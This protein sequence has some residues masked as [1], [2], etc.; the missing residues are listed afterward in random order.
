MAQLTQI[1][2][3]GVTYDIADLISGFVTTSVNN[4]ANYYL[5]SDTYTR[6]EVQ[7]LIGA[8]QQFHYEIY[9]SRSEVTSPASNV[10]YLIG[11][12]G[13]GA[14][15][16]EEYVYDA[17]KQDPWVKI[18]DTTI[19][20]SGYVTTQA[21][22]AAL[23]NYTTTA[24]LTT[25]LSGK[26]DVISDLDT[27][28]AGA[29]L[30]STAYQKPSTGIPATDLAI[31]TSSLA[32]VPADTSGVAANF[33]ETLGVTS[34]QLSDLFHGKY[35]YI[36][37]GADLYAVTYAKYSSDLSY[38]IFAGKA[39][40]YCIWEK[41][42]GFMMS[43]GIDSYESQGYYIATASIINTVSYNRSWVFKEGDIWE[44]PASGSTPK[45]M[46]IYHNGAWVSMDSMFPDVSG[47]ADK[48]NNP[49]SGNFAGLDANGNLTDSGKK[50]SDFATAAQGAKADTAI[51]DLSPIT[52]LIPAQASDQNQLADKAYVNSSIGTA[53]ATFRGAYN[54][55]TDLSLTTAATRAQIATALAGAVSTADN[56]DYAFVQVPT[57]DVTPTEIA[58]VERYKYNGSA[59][60][61]EYA[62]NNSGFTASQWAALNSGITSGLVGKLSALPTNSELMTLLAGKQ[63]TISD[64][65]AIRTGAGLGATA[66]QPEAGKGLFSGSY[67]DLTDTPTI[68]D[69]Q[70]Q[71]DWNQGDNTAKDYI[72][73]KPSIP[74]AQVNSDWNANSGVAQILNKPSIPDAVE[75]NPT[76]PSG[77]TPSDLT[78][79]KVGNGYYGIPQPTVDNTPTKNSA[80][81]V[82]SGGV[83]DA[84]NPS[85]QSNQPQG[86][87]APNVVYDLG[88]LTGTVTFALASPTD[89][90]VP[91]AYHWTFDTGSTAPTITWPSGIIWPDGFTPSVDANKHYEVLVRNGYASMLSYSLS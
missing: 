89:N 23:A 66:V 19:D 75:A 35:E 44:E 6:A 63:D 68:P 30:G 84:I 54:L 33:F 53:T 29:G 60:A 85:V 7:N 46:H 11:P 90:T 62:L 8:I 73:N 34:Q 65:A 47:K 52:D 57:A 9:A 16:Y 74:A 71:S 1:E 10:L 64:L 67:N 51:Q 80:N 91:N 59:W 70:I 3:N 61:F 27:I 83:Y 12:T 55:V 82:K 49:T 69:A 4:L 50:A 24:N 76:V 39:K 32:A 26:Q 87:F 42:D 15:K 28:R 86:G 40:R 41:W 72:K 79:L 58:R 77:T 48:V 37:F 78:G 17:T 22:N 20:L 36:K 21:L 18:G 31:L 38:A 56:N 2:V 5:K 13:T 14:D 88:T 43:A 25:L 45:Q 81:L